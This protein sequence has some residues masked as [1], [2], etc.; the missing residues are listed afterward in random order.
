MEKCSAREHFH[1]GTHKKSQCSLSCVCLWMG[2]ARV[3]VCTR[4]SHWL[5]LQYMRLQYRKHPPLCASRCLRM[6][7]LVN[8]LL[9]L[10]SSGMSHSFYDL[11]CVCVCVCVCVSHDKPGQLPPVKTVYLWLTGVFDDVR[12]LISLLCL[13][14]CS[15]SH[16]H[17]HTHTHT[18]MLKCSFDA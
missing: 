17:T 3:C 18:H 9:C 13:H 15:T 5:F 6:Y 12:A 1:I 2:R 7:N 4:A 8:I 10:R 11:D 14:S 16:T